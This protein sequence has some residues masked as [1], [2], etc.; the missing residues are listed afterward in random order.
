MQ[1]HDP[2]EH[3]VL[4]RPPFPCAAVQIIHALVTTIAAWRESILAD[5][6]TERIHVPASLLNPRRN[7]V[8]LRKLILFGLCVLSAHASLG[9]VATAA[10]A[11]P[12]AQTQAALRID[13]FDVEPVAQLTAGSDLL[14][15]LYGS[16]GGSAAVRIE[17]VV[18]RFM[19]DEVEAGV[20][21]GAYTIRRRDRLTARTMVT[22][23]LRVG[24]RIA[25]DILDESLLVGAASRSDVKRAA[26]AAALVAAPKITRFEAGAVDRVIAGSD[27]FFSVTGSPGGKAAVRINGLKGKIALP[28]TVAGVYEGTY[29]IK[30][31]DRISATSSTTATLRIGDSEVSAPLIGSLLAAPGSV[32]SAR[33]AALR[34]ANCGVVE[35]IHVVEVNGEGSYL[36]KIAG[37]VV[38]A[39]IGSQV[40]QGR[41][42]TAAEIAGAIGGAVAGNEIEKRARKTRHY[43]VTTRLLGGGAQ[44]ISYPTEPAFKVGDKVRVENAVLVPYS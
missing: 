33:V 37:G 38:G 26:D 11:Q 1:A 27:L 42:T 32:A 9:L 14:F 17:G 34:C 40:G 43:D 3:Y 25:T 35:S 23:N 7:I 31:R 28:E 18:D 22:A 36:G 29:T 20:Y 13:G 15:T 10:Q 19:L 30:D 12:A 16:P 21:E 39:V 4:P 2:A 8:N 5:T 6:Q 24:N 44:T 41:G